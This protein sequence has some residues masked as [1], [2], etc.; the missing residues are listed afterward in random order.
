MVP[1]FVAA[2]GRDAGKTT[3]SLGLL[4][5]FRKHGLKAGFIKPVGQRYQVIDG[6]KV[7]ED[8]VLIKDIFALE[9]PLA[10]MSPVAVP[11]GF[12]TEYVHH[13]DKF[14]FLT[15]DI[16]RAFGE[17][18]QHQ[19]VVIVE[20]TGHAG[21]GSIFDLSNA[22]VARLLG[23]KAIIVSEG[24][25]GSAVDEIVLNAALFEKAGVQVI[26][27]VVNKVLEDKY[28]KVKEVVTQALVE[29]G[30]CPVAFLP[31][32]TELT[33]PHVLQVADKLAAEF[34]CG[35]E[36]A[37]DYID[38]VVIAGM[39][40]QN[41]IPLL[42]PRSLVITPGDRVDNILVAVNSHLMH[43]PSKPQVSAI[44]LTHGFRPHE[45]IVELLRR[46]NIPV[47]LTELDTYSVAS[48]VYSMS[49]KTQSSDRHKID[50]IKR[51]VEEHM[52]AEC[53]IGT[54]GGCRNCG[55]RC[56]MRGLVASAP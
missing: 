38:N 43:D 28:H 35:R 5:F 18:G 48:Q 34:L 3:V 53:L 24:G 16:L 44:L 9:V 4:H 41:V 54:D 27:A 33:S 45:T 23:A 31:F 30:L 55:G 47:L 51:M 46:A 25:I 50:I 17:I 10:A 56:A 15:Q 52:S 49:V 2:T 22:T 1:I 6:V 14:A 7:D 21:V 36:H 32:R 26:G 39:E 12:T 13:R 29:R 20:G 42:A 8:S 11:R 40:P 19:D 37:I